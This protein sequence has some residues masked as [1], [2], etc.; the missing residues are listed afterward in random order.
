MGR[1]LKFLLIGFL[2][3]SLGFGALYSMALGN[4][5][6]AS[7][8]PAFT[9]AYL[10]N[11]WGATPTSPKE[12]VAGFLPWDSAQTMWN[13][14][15]METVTREDLQ[16][17]IS[18]GFMGWL[19]KRGGISELFGSLLGVQR[20]QD[21][22]GSKSLYALFSE[23]LCENPKYGE[24]LKQYDD[25][26][27]REH[28]M[29]TMVDVPDFDLVIGRGE[30]VGEWN[31]TQ[32]INGTQ[33]TII[34]RQ[35]QLEVN[36][37]LQKVVKASFYNEEGVLLMDPDVYKSIVPLW[38]WIGW[39][40][41]GY[42]LYYGEDI[43]LTIRYRNYWIDPVTNTPVLE[44]ANF[45]DVF[46]IT[47]EELIGSGLAAGVIG[48]IA[49]IVGSV[50][51]SL[52]GLSAGIMMGVALTVAKT[53]LDMAYERAWV[54]DWGIRTVTRVHYIYPWTILGYLTSWVAQYLV[55]FDGTVR[56]WL[57][58]SYVTGIIFTGIG[59]NALILSGV[60]AMILAEGIKN[61][62]IP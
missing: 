37:T 2:V 48:L 38:I 13:D 59:V 42:P 6:A 24:Y 3:V 18:T 12:A 45:H 46:T 16:V 33:F 17:K 22:L 54:N 30:L 14:G 53:E 23:F 9:L 31:H 27:A 25:L 52:L 39:W 10:S 49:I 47:F 7:G 11:S 4:I 8:N 55:W 28:M 26:L 36:G 29:A 57:P 50:G 35:Y 58:N 41:F 43:S 20:E 40:P 15:Q 5:S 62:W 34:C 21:F 56:E 61:S 1:G 60:E 51:I 44:A 19:A 32:T